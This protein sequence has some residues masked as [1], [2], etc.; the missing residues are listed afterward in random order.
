M[1]IDGSMQCSECT[2]SVDEF[3]AIAEQWEFWSDGRD[4]LPYCPT[5]SQREFCGEAT[6][7]VRLVHPRAGSNGF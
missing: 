1:P 7:P 6:Q 3:V 4:P 2:R 5:C